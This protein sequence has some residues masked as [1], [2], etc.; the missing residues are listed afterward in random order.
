[1]ASPTTI[2]PP[3]TTNIIRPAEVATGSPRVLG[4]EKKKEKAKRD[5]RSSSANP[6]NAHVRYS[7]PISGIRSCW[8]MILRTSLLLPYLHSSHPPILAGANIE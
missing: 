4:C 8:M 7:P 3:S 2:A 1:M 5:N 6:Q